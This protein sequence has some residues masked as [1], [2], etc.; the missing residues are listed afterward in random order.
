MDLYVYRLKVDTPAYQLY[1]SDLL[2]GVPYW[3]DPVK[4]IAL[5]RI[6][7]GYRPA[8]FL[9]ATDVELVEWDQLMQWA[10]L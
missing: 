6:D 8:C 5:C 7:D 2:L 4:V 3:N 10:R 9:D 1:E